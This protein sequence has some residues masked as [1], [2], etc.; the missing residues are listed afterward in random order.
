M[1]PE[2]HHNSPMASTPPPCS[3]RPFFNFMQPTTHPWPPYGHPPT[4]MQLIVIHQLPCSPWPPSSLYIL[5]TH[6]IHNHTHFAILDAHQ[7]HHH[8]P[9]FR[10]IFDTT[11]NIISFFK[12]WAWGSNDLLGMLRMGSQRK[13]WNCRVLTTTHKRHGA[14]LGWGACVSQREHVFFYY[15]EPH[16]HIVLLV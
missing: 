14:I 3:P 12:R 7:T 6:Q 11:Y 9:H 10:L 4:P 5:H 16:P 15:S 13:I 8:I 1:Q 2:P